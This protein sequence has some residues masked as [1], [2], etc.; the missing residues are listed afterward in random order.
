MKKIPPASFLRQKQGLESGFEETAFVGDPPVHLF[1]VAVP[2]VK[3][4][5][6]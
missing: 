6:L 3:L 4:C 2:K 5:T 1:G